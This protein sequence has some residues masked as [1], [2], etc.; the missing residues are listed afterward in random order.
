MV[1]LNPEKMESGALPHKDRT[2]NGNKVPFA[3]LFPNIQFAFQYR[4]HAFILKVSRDTDKKLLICF[5]FVKYFETALQ[6]RQFAW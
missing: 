3:R 6:F 4:S 5:Q 1:Y 2:T